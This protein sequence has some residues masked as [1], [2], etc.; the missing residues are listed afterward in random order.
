MKYSAERGICMFAYNNEQLDYGQ[1]SL[2]ASKQAKQHLDVP[3][4]QLQIMEHGPG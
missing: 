1:F 4:S 2:L 3:M